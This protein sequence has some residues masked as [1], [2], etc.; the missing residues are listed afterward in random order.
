M[1]SG[2][3]VLPDELR[4][5]AECGGPE[6]VQEILTVFQKD[7]AERLAKLR[8]ALNRNQLSLARS[9]AHAIKGAAGQ[10]GASELWTVCREVE[11]RAASVDG[12]G[13]RELLPRLEAIFADVCRAMAG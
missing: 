4:Q 1:T 12:A 9:Q 7:T 6:M 10:V 11:M 5:L 2:A 8:D 13:V 3:W